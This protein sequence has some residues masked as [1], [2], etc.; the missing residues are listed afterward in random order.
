MSSSVVGI[1]AAEAETVAPT[2]ASP[3]RPA[4]QRLPVLLADGRGMRLQSIGRCGHAW[5]RVHPGT[6]AEV[7]EVKQ[8]RVT[9]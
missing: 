5:M 7:P 4:S 6:V 1:G 3:M 9:A 2:R 8:R